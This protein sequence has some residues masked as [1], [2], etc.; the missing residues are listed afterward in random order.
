MRDHLIR[1][2]WRL[3]AFGAAAGIG[4][5]VVV[6]L[7][8]II[9][10]GPTA[11]AAALLGAGPALLIV[12]SGL[13]GLIAASRWD[14]GLILA[15]AVTIY[16]VE[17]IALWRL[18]GWLRPWVERTATT[19]WLVAG[20]LAATLTWMVGLILTFRHLRI[21]VYDGAAQRERQDTQI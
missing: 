11:A 21:P 18:A 16:G 6:A 1:Q 3:V 12:V 13:A 8:A 19:S 14:V 20:V 2:G 7:V 17:M 10:A 9:A 4:G 5:G 15:L